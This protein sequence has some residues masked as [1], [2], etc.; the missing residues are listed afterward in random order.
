MGFLMP[1]APSMPPP[2]PAP[3]PMA[4]PAT[5]ANPAVAQSA[6][7]SKARAAAAAVNSGGTNPTGPQGLSQPIS[8]AKSTL[9]GGTSLQ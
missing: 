6:A 4:A 7:A 5:M 9:L 8:T 2:P 3:P 1:S